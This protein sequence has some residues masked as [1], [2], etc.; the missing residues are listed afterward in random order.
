MAATVAW[1]ALFHRNY[2]DSAVPAYGSI[3]MH[4]GNLRFVLWKYVAAG[5]VLGASWLIA[6]L[7]VGSREQPRQVA[8]DATEPLGRIYHSGGE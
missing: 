3:D 4:L 1:A 7:Q 8:A 5:M 6:S 2:W